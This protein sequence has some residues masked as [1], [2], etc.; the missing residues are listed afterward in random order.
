MIFCST[1]PTRKRFDF[2]PKRKG[3]LTF[4]GGNPD[5]QNKD[6][7]IYI[8]IIITAI[9]H[10]YMGSTKQIYSKA[11]KKTQSQDHITFQK[12][13]NKNISLSLSKI[14]RYLSS[15]M[16]R[17]PSSKGYLCEFYYSTKPYP[18]QCSQLLPKIACH[19]LWLR[20]RS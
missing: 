20:P 18:T 4:G 17:K 3:P 13:T 9:S 6:I 14:D 15:L 5:G 1:L 7:Y 12:T 11:P 19:S 10:P 16:S 8:S 2:H